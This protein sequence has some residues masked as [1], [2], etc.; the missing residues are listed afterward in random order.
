MYARATDD[1]YV[2]LFGRTAR[3]LYVDFQVEDKTGLRDKLTKKE[4]RSIQNFED[5][6]MRLID[7]SDMHPRAAVQDARQRLMMPVS[8]RPLLK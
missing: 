4:L 5:M 7:N 8:A 1:T 3:Q 6:S 2:A